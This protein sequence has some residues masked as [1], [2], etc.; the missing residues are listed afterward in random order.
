MIERKKTEGR[1]R[2]SG[3]QPTNGGSIML[4]AHHAEAFFQI[5]INGQPFPSGMTE[6][7]LAYSLAAVT[8]TLAAYGA[9]SM[10]RNVLAWRRKPAA[11]P[12][13]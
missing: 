12:M 5:E 7:T 13:A 3:S 2:Q 10:L 11:K 4:F 1:C 6:H 8:L 9:Y